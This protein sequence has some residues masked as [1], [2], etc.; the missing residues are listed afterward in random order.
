MAAS[1]ARANDPADDAFDYTQKPRKF[2]KIAGG[3]PARIGKRSTDRR[4]EGCW[5]T[6]RPKAAYLPHWRYRVLV[7]P[8]DGSGSRSLPALRRAAPSSHHHATPIKHV[9][10]IVQENRSFNNLFLGYPGATTETYGYDTNGNKI[11]LQGAKLGDIWDPGH[12]ASA[13]FAACDGQGKL[14][15]TKCKMDGWNHESTR[16]HAPEERAYWFVPKR[17]RTLLE[18]ARQ[19]VLSDNTFSSNLDGSL[20]PI[21]IVAAFAVTPSII[22]S[23]QWGCHGGRT[24]R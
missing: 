12:N 23:S 8:F 10:F 1:D 11:A 9:V 22:R 17:D 24:I 21:S 13:F 16:L 2:K 5:V 18:I 14:P 3:E 15:G 19:Y 20:P 6:I 7:R 4:R